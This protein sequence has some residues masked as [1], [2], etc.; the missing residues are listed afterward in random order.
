MN[1]H[2]VALALILLHGPGG[3]QI[4]VN[5]NKVSTLRD[6]RGEAHFAPHTHCLVITSNGKFIAVRE[7]CGA[8]R[9][10]VEATP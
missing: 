8:V 10:L 3:Q 6:P 9:H 2:A 1:P 7:T 4:H 5:P